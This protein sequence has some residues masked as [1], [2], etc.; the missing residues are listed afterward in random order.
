[1]TA[2]K[3]RMLSDQAA[4]V[5]GLLA[6]K[7]LRTWHGW[8]I[9]QKTSIP[10]GTLYPMLARLAERQVLVESWD[11]DTNDGRNTRTRH[12]YRVAGDGR[13]A[14]IKLAEWRQKKPA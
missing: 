14:R 13:L 9:T 4:A 8:E 6:Q 10:G 3:E 5:L 12:Y 11:T 1:V 2:R 7:P